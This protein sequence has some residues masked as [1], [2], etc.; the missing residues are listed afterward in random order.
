MPKITSSEIL[1]PVGDLNSAVLFPGMESS[2]VKAQMDQW[3]NDGF[4]ALD[5]AGI[6]ESDEKANDA[7]E[8]FVSYKAYYNKYID[9]VS[10]PLRASI[11]N[12]ASDEYTIEQVREFQ[13]I[14]NSHLASYNAIIAE[15]LQADSTVSTTP[16]SMAMP[17]E[18]SW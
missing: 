9:M 15:I 7:V 18:F 1:T 14:A 2:E 5:S 11:D 16:V 3:V 4:K 10:N 6:A 13:K 17:T 8:Q 12:E